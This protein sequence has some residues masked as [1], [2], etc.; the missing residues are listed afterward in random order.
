MLVL[1][2]FHDRDNFWDLE[3]AA[4]VCIMLPEEVS[5]PLL[6][7]RIRKRLQHVATS[8][9]DTANSP[10]AIFAQGGHV[11]GVSQRPRSRA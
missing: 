8:R 3:L 5:S 4:P 1:E 7:I 10:H 6:N 11:P 2:V 9:L